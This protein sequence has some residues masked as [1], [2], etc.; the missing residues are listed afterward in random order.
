MKA[1]I[2]FADTIYDAIIKK[3][4][5]GAP[6]QT[7]QL[8][9]KGKMLIDTYQLDLLGKYQSKNL[10]GVLMLCDVLIDMGYSLDT[11]LIK[12]GLQQVRETTGI[13]ARFEIVSTAPTIIYDVAHN[14][15]GLQL[16]MRQIQSMRF[17]KLHIIC[18]FVADKNIEKALS[19]FTPN[20]N[21]YFTQAQIPRAL[22]YEQLAEIAKK[23]NLYGMALPNVNIALNTA[24]QSAQEEDI[25]LVCGSFFVIAE[26]NNS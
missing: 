2:Y 12:Q 17:N 7:I 14:A 8:V 21:Y 9:H 22:N 26:I 13:K 16:V 23:I 20:A 5:T 10:I 15:E 24:K 11:Q 6:H 18:G 1:P 25:I 19:T 3:Q 4:I